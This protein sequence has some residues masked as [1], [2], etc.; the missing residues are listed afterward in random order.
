MVFRKDKNNNIN[1]KNN[2]R[3]QSAPLSPLALKSNSVRD[4]YDDEGDW[5][6][7]D[8]LRT[9][10]KAARNHNHNYH[11]RS[12]INNKNHQDNSART[13]NRWKGLLILQLL[14]Y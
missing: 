11:S 8:G 4:D 14:Q 10:K 6:S 13:L 9:K 7:R 1:N 5:A 3:K 12:N 2:H